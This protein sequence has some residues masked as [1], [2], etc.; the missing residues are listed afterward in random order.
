MR[1]NTAQRLK[2][3]VPRTFW[4]DFQDR[5]PVDE[6]AHMPEK[7]APFGK[8][9]L[10]SANPVQLAALKSDATFYA[11]GNVDDCVRLVRSARLTLAAIAKAEAA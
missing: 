11:E 9:I 8:R 6:E 3:Y 10:I 1:A 2:V 7:L 5:A 4:D